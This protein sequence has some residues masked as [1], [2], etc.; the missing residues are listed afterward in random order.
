MGYFLQKCIQDH[1][2]YEEEIVV[3][4]MVINIRKICNLDSK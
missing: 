1:D 2:G 3:I 4:E